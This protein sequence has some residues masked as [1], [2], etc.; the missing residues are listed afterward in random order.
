MDPLGQNK[1]GAGGGGMVMWG[2]FLAL[3]E[4]QASHFLLS[5]H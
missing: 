5:H 3:R 1:A 4:N 2:G